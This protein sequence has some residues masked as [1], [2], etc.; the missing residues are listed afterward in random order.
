MIVMHGAL[1]RAGAALL[2]ALL[3]GVTGAALADVR[4][5]TLYQRTGRSPWVILGEVID[6]D[7]RFAEVKVVEMLKGEYEHPTLRIVH[8][9]ESFL[10]ESWEEKIEYG[11]GERVVLFLKRYE[12]PEED[13]KIPDKLA[14][15]DMFAPSF[16]ASGKFTLPEEGQSAYMEA[17]REYCRVTSIMDPVTR[18][19][20]LLGFLRS[21]NPHVVQT[22]LEQVLERQL[23]TDEEVPLLLDLADSD[24]GPVRL[25]ALQVLGQVAEDLAVS[26]RRLQDQQDIVNRLKAKV[27]G[28]G[29]DLYRAEAIRV[30][31]TLGGEE[32]RAFIERIAREDRSDLV[33]Y[34][35]S[36]ALMELS[37]R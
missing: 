14:G 20:A 5:L 28:D 24:R 36:A 34:Q 26:K 19:D 35:A 33:R 37:A 9:L 16:G 22:G 18:E 7:D 8:K 3:A 10:R 23:A 21:R 13:G 11:T 4:P 30:V 6:G 31:A 17:L 32:E 1:K 27:L 2:A 25:N 29:S 15:E 12:P